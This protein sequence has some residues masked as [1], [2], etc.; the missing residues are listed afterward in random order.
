MRQLVLQSFERWTKNQTEAIPGGVQFRAE[1][2]QKTV[3][4]ES[5]S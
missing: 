2:P 4:F 1:I 5:G 3:L